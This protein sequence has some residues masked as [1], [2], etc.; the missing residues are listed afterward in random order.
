MSLAGTH[1]LSIPLPLSLPQAKT[2]RQ[3]RACEWALR[4]AELLLAVASLTRIPQRKD[5][6]E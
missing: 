3:N 5:A 1:S 6:L 4:D 2:K